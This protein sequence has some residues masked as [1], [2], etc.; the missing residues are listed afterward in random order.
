[1]RKTV[2]NYLS[3]QQ[4]QIKGVVRNYIMQVNRCWQEYREKEQ[5]YSVEQMNMNS[6]I[7][8]KL[9]GGFSKGWR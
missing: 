5:L 6:T 4:L 2:Q 7:T 9:C 1:M 8:E 3:L